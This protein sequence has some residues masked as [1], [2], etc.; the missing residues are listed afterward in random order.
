MVK[1]IIIAILLSSNKTI[2]SLIYKNCVF[3][4]IYIIIK[5]LDT[6]TYQSQNRPA[7]LFLGSISI[8]YKEL[9]DSINNDRDLKTK[10]YYLAL[11]TV[12][13]YM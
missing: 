4:S 5:N 9:K 10:I 13:K 12:L 1:A 3:L 7:I 6:K 11:K 2:R 8:F